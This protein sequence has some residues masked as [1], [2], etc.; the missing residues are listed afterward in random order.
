MLSLGGLFGLGR[1]TFDPNSPPEPGSVA[2]YV[3]ELDRNYWTRPSAAQGQ[4]AGETMPPPD[5][6][7]EEFNILMAKGR[8]V[9]PSGAGLSAYYRYYQ[10]SGGTKPKEDKKDILSKITGVFK[11]S[12]KAKDSATASMLASASYSQPVS[13]SDGGGILNYA[14]PVI[15]GGL[16]LGGAYYALRRFI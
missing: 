14:L 13:A 12:S 2:V 6:D 16:L 10:A 4:K 11:P 9:S 3:P 15:G 1:L 7:E 5:I 8:A